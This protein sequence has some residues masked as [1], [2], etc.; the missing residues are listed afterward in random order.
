[1][2]GC[3]ET[4]FQNKNGILIQSQSK[5]DLVDAIMLYINNTNQINIQGIKSREIA[6]NYFCTTKNSKKIIKLL[7]IE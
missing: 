3:K 7:G 1:V 4:I 2:P 5:L 6:E